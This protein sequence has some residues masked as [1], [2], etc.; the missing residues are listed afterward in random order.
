MYWNEILLFSSCQRFCPVKY[1]PFDP[2]VRDKY[3]VGDDYLPTWK[4]P[5]LAKYYKDLGFGMKRSFDAWL[6]SQ[7]KV[8]IILVNKIRCLFISK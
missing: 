6:K 5:S 8:G 1:H 4:V 3:V 2:E 7:D